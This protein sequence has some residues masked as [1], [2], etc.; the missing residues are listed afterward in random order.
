MVIEYLCSQNGEA[1]SPATVRPSVRYL[2]RQNN[3]KTNVGI[4]MK[5]GL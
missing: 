3:F 5:V 1:Y 2:V 4:L